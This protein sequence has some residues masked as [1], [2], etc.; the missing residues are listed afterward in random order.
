MSHR[1]HRRV[2]V[3]F[4]AL[5]AAL[6]LAAATGAPVV[7]AADRPIGASAPVAPPEKAPVAPGRPGDDAAAADDE[8]IEFLGSVGDTDD[9]EDWLDFLHHT[10]IEQVAKRGAKPPTRGR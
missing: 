5:G 4:A 2:A 6:S 8:L 1:A 3:R 7:L 10:D 9:G